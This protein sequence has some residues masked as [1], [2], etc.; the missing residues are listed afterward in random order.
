MPP[1]ALTG[2]REAVTDWTE[3]LEEGALLEERFQLIG[4]APDLGIGEVLSVVRL[5][6]GLGAGQQFIQRACIEPMQDQY[7]G[8]AEERGVERE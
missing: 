2:W 6:Q 4:P 7:L 5:G 3:I 8:A 1:N